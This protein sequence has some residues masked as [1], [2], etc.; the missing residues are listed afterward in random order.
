[1]HRRHP[2]VTTCFPATWRFDDAPETTQALS[3]QART[4]ETVGDS[5]GRFVW[6]ELTTTDLAAAKTFYA[7]VM[8]WRAHDVS[9]PG[10]DYALLVAGKTTAA[11]VVGLPEGAAEMGAKPRWMGYVG[12]DDVDATAER[13]R[14]LGGAVHIP[15]E[16]IPDIS[17]FS[18]VADP[19]AAMFA[20]FKGLKP[21]QQPTAP[22]RLGRVT[23]HELLAADGEAAFAFYGALFGWQKADADTGPTGIYQTFSAGGQTIGGMFTKPPTVPDTFWLYYFDIGDIDAAAA[24]V[25]AGGGQ[26]LEGP[27]EVA[28]GRWILRCTDPQGA[29]FGLEGKRNSKAVGYFESAPHP[30]GARGRRWHW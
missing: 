20:L 9:M 13:I 29:M 4:G 23:W 6:Y 22:A 15:P 12:V 11:A 27:L 17:R 16:D 18:V 28:G 26:I 24:R 1:L 21:G 25:T 10:M 5:H 14:Q 8:G 7:A 19:Q 3:L 2:A 30:S